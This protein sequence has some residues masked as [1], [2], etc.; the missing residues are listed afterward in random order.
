MDLKREH[1]CE[2]DDR[3]VEDAGDIARRQVSLEP[4][5]PSLFFRGHRLPMEREG[6]PPRFIR[7]G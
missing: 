7:F 4:G 3:A 5:G 1:E 6:A 2:A